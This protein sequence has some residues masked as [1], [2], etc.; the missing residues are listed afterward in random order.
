MVRV[1]SVR[2]ARF[3]VTGRRPQHPPHQT[4]AMTRGPNPGC[5]DCVEPVARPSRLRSRS[6]ALIRPSRR[7]PALLIGAALILGSLPAPTTAHDP[8]PAPSGA[9]P[10]SSGEP[11]GDGLLFAGRHEETEAGGSTAEIVEPNFQEEVIWGPPTFDFPVDVAFA[12]DGRVFVAEKGGIIKEFTSLADPSASVYADLSAQVHD[13][14]D[15]GL[16]GMVLDPNFT[17]NDRMYVSYAHSTQW[18]DECPDP[19]DGPGGNIDGCMVQGR[20]AVLT[21]GSDLDVL[22]TTGAS[23]FPAIR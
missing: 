15:R 21:D 14:W 4:E 17:S 22:L 23:S 6:S 1:G 8:V 20:V 3:D 2:A 18:G 12:P 7:I 19:P 11:A 16:L 5:L 10:T 9:P 13:F